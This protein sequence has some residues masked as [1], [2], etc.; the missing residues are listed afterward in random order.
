M[1]EISASGLETV[2]NSGITTVWSFEKDE[3]KGRSRYSQ[4]CSNNQSFDRQVL[5]QEGNKHREGAM[6]DDGK[7]ERERGKKR[8]AA[9]TRDSSCTFLRHEGTL[10]RDCLSV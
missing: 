8:F 2:A 6:G 3:V 9:M 1:C 7:G 4:R 5:T 10:S